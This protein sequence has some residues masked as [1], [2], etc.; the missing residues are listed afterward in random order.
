MLRAGRAEDPRRATPG[1]ELLVDAA[2]RQGGPRRGARLPLLG[3][4]YR[5]EDF[6]QIYRGLR[7]TERQGAAGSRELLENLLRRPLREAVLALVD[8]VPDTRAWRGPQPTTVPRPLDYE[9]L[10]GP[11][12]EEPGETVRCL[13]AY[14][15]GE[16]GLTA[17]R[18]AAG[19]GEP[20]ASA[21]FFLLAGGRARP[22]LLAR[23][24][25]KARHA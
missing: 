1:H 25:G 23:D 13:A 14:H 15:V 11:L 9:E 24:A 10:L 7:S 6:E 2:A 4:Q 16:L 18:P 8:D 3:L 22:G 21:G 5:G 20:S 19:G 17:L 12:L